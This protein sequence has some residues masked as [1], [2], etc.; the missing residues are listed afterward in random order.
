MVFSL[1]GFIEQAT[2]IIC[3]LFSANSLIHISKMAFISSNSG[4]M[5]QNDGRYL[6]RITRE[7]FVS[8]ISLILLFHAFLSWRK[9]R[10]K[11]DILTFWIA[12][13]EFSIS[14]SSIRE[15]ISQTEVSKI[16]S[17]IVAP[18]LLV[19]NKMTN[20]YLTSNKSM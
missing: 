5:V 1:I 4:F 13:L 2:L 15:W 11:K 3:G 18:R 16:N 12:R 14:N 9:S 7:T 19:T 17:R 10:F 8:I 20:S 6:P